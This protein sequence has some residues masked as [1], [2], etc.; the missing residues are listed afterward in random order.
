MLDGLFIAYASSIVA[1]SF[2][3]NENFSAVVYSLYPMA[4]TY[5]SVI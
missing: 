2:E 1:I 4:I 5:Q 3:I